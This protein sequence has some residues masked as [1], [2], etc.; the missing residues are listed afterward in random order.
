MQKGNFQCKNSSRATAATCRPQTTSKNV[1]PRQS[2]T[3]SRCEK[4]DKNNC[5]ETV[6][7][8]ERDI[9]QAATR[10]QGLVLDRSVT[11]RLCDDVQW[12]A[13]SNSA[14][15]ITITASGARLDLRGH[16]LSQ[17]NSSSAGNIGII[18]EENLEQ[19]IIENGVLDGFSAAGILVREGSECVTIRGMEFHRI[20][21]HGEIAIVNPFLQG[22]AAAVLVNGAVDNHVSHVTVSDSKFC[23]LGLLGTAPVAFQGKISGN[24]LTLSETPLEPVNL[25]FV[26][27]GPGVA[28]NTRVLATT[29]D[30]LRFTLTATPNVSSLTQFQLSDPAAQ[31]N[32][33]GSVS[34]VFTNL[35]D[36]VVVTDVEIDGVFGDF[37][38]QGISPSQGRGLILKR[39]VISNLRSF[40]LA[41][42]VSPFE[43]QDSIIEDVDLSDFVVSLQNPPSGQFPVGNDT[44]PRGA[45]AIKYSGAENFIVRRVN[46]QGMFIRTQVPTVAIA[47]TL[48]AEGIGLSDLPVFNSQGQIVR[49]IPSAHGVFEDIVTQDVQSDGGLV[50][51]NRNYSSGYEVS[52]AS[53]DAYFHH[54]TAQN[55]GVTGPGVAFGFGSR[56]RGIRDEAIVF[57][58]CTA[59]NI[60]SANGGDWAAGY[61]VNGNRFQVTKSVANEIHSENG[62]GDGIRIGFFTAQTPNAVPIAAS[63]SI[64]R[65]NHL[66]NADHAAIHNL[67][68]ADVTLPL[69]ETNIIVENW[70][71]LSGPDGT[72]PNYVGVAHAWIETI[73]YQAGPP[74]GAVSNQLNVDIRTGV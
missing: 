61:F 20:G 43:H 19:V 37:V 1:Q 53:K 74:Q 45:E 8:S 9:Q 67:V 30:P 14:A 55:I 62:E 27:T 66:T 6:Q 23:D 12:T 73:D 54:C 50:E 49:R 33:A 69:L 44:F 52:D 21:Y 26:L 7:I 4:R 11:Y 2:V 15:A 60:T 58:E 18:V 70:A 42:G 17:L 72:D 10:T 24:T 57:H 71:A 16:R 48:T 40:G 28:A 5:D 31:F 41:L 13:R 68:P 46:I 59:Q 39:S 29:N 65:G 25:N 63:N 22:A 36:H 56:G 35:A 3:A 38:A 47:N 34:A 51:G 64:I 32:P